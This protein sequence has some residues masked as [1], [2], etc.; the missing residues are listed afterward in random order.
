MEPQPAYISQRT[1]L[2]DCFPELTPGQQQQIEALYPLYAEWNAKINVISRKDIGN[3]YTRHV[4]HSLGIV[5][6]LR[7]TP[8]TEVMDLGS[9]GG[10]PGIPLAIYFPRVHFCLL[11]ATAK[12]IRVAQEVARAIGLE[13]LSFRHGRAEE[14]TAQYDFVVSRGVMPLADQVKLI[15]R[16]IKKQQ[17][18]ALP[19]GLI[20]LKGGDLTHETAPFARKA[21]RLELKEYFHDP[22]FKTK[23]VV[24]IPL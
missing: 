6:L 10:F 3:L 9:G 21:L 17:Q 7:F 16:N 4:L 12:K 20:T 5:R 22:Y 8:A 2:L 14:E 13:N 23:Q 15:G 1:F 18:N 19:N 24:Y 11:E